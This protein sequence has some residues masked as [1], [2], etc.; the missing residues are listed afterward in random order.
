MMMRVHERPALVRFLD[1]VA[2]HLFG[3]S[4]VGN[5]AVFQRLDDSDT[6]GRAAQHLLGFLADRLHFAGTV[7][8]SNG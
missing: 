5:H 7:V 6:A 1:E 3:H 8:E 2:E 4:E